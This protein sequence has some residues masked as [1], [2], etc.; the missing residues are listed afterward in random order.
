MS[1][2]RINEEKTPDSLAVI[3]RRLEAD[4]SK[5]PAEAVQKVVFSDAEWKDRLT[6]AQYR[7][8]RQHKTE[9]AFCGLLLTQRKSG[10]YF[11]AGCGLPLFSSESKYK[12]GT[13]WPSFFEP[14]AKE[15][16]EE[17]EDL[18]YN[19]RRTEIRCSRCS[20]HLG[21]VFPDGPEPSGLRYCLN[22]DALIFIEC[23]SLSTAPAEAFT[24]AAGKLEKATFSAGRFWNVEEAFRSL[25]GVIDTKVGYIGGQTESP[26]Y[27]QVSGGETGHA[28]A[29]EVIFDPGRISYNDLLDIFW[30]IHDPT[31]QDSQGSD[32]G[33]QYRSAIFTHSKKQ[34]NEARKSMD[35]KDASGEYSWPIVTQIRPATQFWPAEEHHQR[36]IVKNGS[37]HNKQ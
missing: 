2:T 4:G 25:P 32:F 29:V 35:M 20:G 37:H 12:S 24:A 21:H 9:P 34:L 10:I 7:V 31:S 22:S 11:C 27:E 28:E 30:S 8:L 36:Y 5:G 16:I 19:M 18:S 14:Y 26:T 3:V 33:T 15:N 6:E 1:N 13:G 23:D 17:F